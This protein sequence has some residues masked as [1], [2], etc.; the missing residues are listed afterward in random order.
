MTTPPEDFE[1]SEK[2]DS[3]FQ[4]WVN[5][6]ISQAQ[7]RWA[8]E[9][10]IPYLE[11]ITEAI[12][13]SIPKVD[14][15]EIVRT[16][17]NNVIDYMERRFEARQQNVVDPASIGAV[18][19]E[20]AEIQQRL[21][22]VANGHGE[23]PGVPSGPSVGAETTS[24]I[25]ALVGALF[26]KVGPPLVKSWLEIQEFQLKKL[27]TMLRVQVTQ[28]NPVALAEQV[29]RTNPMAA[30]FM[31]MMWSGDPWQ[32]QIPGMMANTADATTRALLSGL[33]RSGAL[34][35]SYVDRV[36]NPASPGAS[37]NPLAPVAPGWP[38]P[39]PSPIG[40]ESAVPSGPGSGVST[41]TPGPPSN[42]PNGAAVMGF[43]RFVSRYR[44][45][46]PISMRGLSR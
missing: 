22:Q 14:T 9:E 29:A 28:T 42:L 35:P 15:G 2:S 41:V 20:V 45:R 17:T 38:N 43:S 33:A 4:E 39:T 6:L 16:V 23:N 12:G 30:R 11:K 5:G 31:G 19:D 37:P 7:A 24:R 46:P 21:S 10:L 27:E 36:L 34:N 26:E 32:A 25:A 8:Q 13:Q 3:S 1:N 44:V 18:P 40:R